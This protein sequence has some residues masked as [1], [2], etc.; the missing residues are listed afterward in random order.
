METVQISWLKSLPTQA[1]LTQDAETAFPLTLQST[2]RTIQIVYNSPISYRHTLLLPLKPLTLPTEF[3]W[4]SS[5]YAPN[6]AS[7][8]QSRASPTRHCLGPVQLQSRASPTRHW[9][10]RGQKHDP[11][12]P[13]LPDPILIEPPGVSTRLTYPAKLPPL[14]RDPT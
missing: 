2:E 12:S 4:T 5:P 13:K 6:R 7:L 10:S 8:D 14:K 9:S 11:K 3:I 1:L